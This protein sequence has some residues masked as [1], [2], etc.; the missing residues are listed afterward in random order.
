V[1]APLSCFIALAGRVLRPPK[2]GITECMSDA[3]QPDVFRPDPLDHDA[4]QS[5][6]EHEL[7]GCTFKDKRLGPRL[8]SILTQLASRPG[9]SIPLACQD[10]AA[11]KAAYRFFDNARVDESEIL[12]GHFQ[13][14]FGR[15]PETTEP[16]LVL[17]DTTEFSYKREHT[18]AIGHTTEVYRGVDKDGM[19]RLH[20]VCGLL[21]H[22]SLVVTSEGLP[23]GLAAIK[24]WSRDKFKGT[25]ALSK[26]INPTRVPIDEKE[27]VRWL[28]NMRQSTERLAA[29]GRCVHIGDREA[30]IY[31]LFCTA[32]EL[33]T[34]F[35]IRTC[36]DRRAGSGDHTI[37][38][39]M[40]E[41]RCKG[42]HRVEVTD[43]KGNVSTAVIELRYRRINVLPPI[44]KQSRYPSLQLTVLHAT[45]RGTPVEREAIDWKLVTDLPVR[46]RAEAIEKLDWY[47]LRWRIETF[48]KILKSG[49]RAEELRL[50][51]AERLVHVLAVFCILAWRIY[52]LTMLQRTAAG[53]KPTMAF[54]QLEIELL[55]RLASKRG[56]PD[57]Q[58]L[59]LQET[60]IELARLGGY[61]NRSSDRPPGITVIWRGM[62]RLSDIAFGYEIAQESCG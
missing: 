6:V 3:H 20:T 21:M 56:R 48:H 24:F 13:A 32:A 29:P 58:L 4:I 37:S 28:E 2:D 36:V 61:L 39:E 34:H 33:G 16:V 9:G 27:S 50:R 42:V 17:H 52:W 38:D 10:W 8:R 25:N 15:M 43:R 49:C 5:W 41:V 7:S 30:D 31:E 45:E 23:L 22:S 60:L 40:G 51:T 26:K 44:G 59:S 35:V 18:E 46:S 53:A 47:A 1:L 14:T 19:P 62:T 55:K 57:A 54:T 12:E 11:T